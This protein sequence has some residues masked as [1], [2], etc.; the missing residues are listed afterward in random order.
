MSDAPFQLRSL[1]GGVQELGE[2][3]REAAHREVMEETGVEIELLG[4]I[5][6]IDSVR[7]DDADRVQFHYTLVDMAAEWRGGEPRPGDDAMGARWVPLAEIEAYLA[8]SE[9]VRVIREGLALRDAGGPAGD[10]AGD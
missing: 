3:V 1:P 8:W 10:D 5:D 6:V 7:R 4:L 9:T 2:S